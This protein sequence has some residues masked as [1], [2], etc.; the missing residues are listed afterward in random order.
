MRAASVSKLPLP[1]AIA[2]AL[3]VLCIVIAI[4]M[5]RRDP[6]TLDMLRIL[7]LFEL[8][9]AVLV[10]AIAAYNLPFRLTIPGKYSDDNVAAPDARAQCRMMVIFQGIEAGPQYLREQHLNWKE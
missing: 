3:S 1:G 9:R 4:Q 8:I 6:N 5:Y 10:I 7:I 2:V